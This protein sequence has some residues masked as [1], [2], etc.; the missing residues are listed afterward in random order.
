MRSL[1][2]RLSPGLAAHAKRSQY[3]RKATVQRSLRTGKLRSARTVLV[4]GRKPTR[5]ATSSARDLARRARS[6]YAS[7]PINS[8]VTSPL[9]QGGEW[10]RETWP[11]RGS[12]G[13]GGQADGNAH[14]QI[15]LGAWDSKWGLAPS[16]P[17]EGETPALRNKFGQRPRTPPLC[18]PSTHQHDCFAD[19]HCVPSGR[20]GGGAGACGLLNGPSVICI[21]HGPR[22]ACAPSR[23]VC[24]CDPLDG[25]WSPC[26]AR[27]SRERLSVGA[28]PE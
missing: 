25:F 8:V 20:V 13:G 1:A 26:L 22:G 18:S 3:I 27:V 15:A 24:H 7:D 11:L 12:E 5:I 16:A 14:E 6:P 4:G 28:R 21:L 19:V 10:G 2:D 17:Q 9:P 23:G